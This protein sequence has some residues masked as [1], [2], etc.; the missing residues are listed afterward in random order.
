MGFHLSWQKSAA[1]MCFVCLL[2]LLVFVLFSYC[3][4]ETV[5]HFNAAF[6]YL[7]SPVHDGSWL[8]LLGSFSLQ[9]ITDIIFCSGI[10]VCCFMLAHPGMAVYG[11]IH[12]SLLAIMHSA[13][14]TLY[15]DHGTP[16][17]LISYLLLVCA[18]SMVSKFLF[19]FWS[20]QW[21]PYVAMYFIPS[22]LPLS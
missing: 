9:A 1:C 21:L 12:A 13:F 11:K 14:R 15:F 6:T 17:W 19:K 7:V 5:Y 3:L 10:H 2:N 4:R 8:S 18:H 22:F 20:Q 16:G